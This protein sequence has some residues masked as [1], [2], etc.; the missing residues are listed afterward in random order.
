MSWKMLPL[1]LERGKHIIN[2]LPKVKR[3][4]KNEENLGTGVHEDSHTFHFY[5]TSYS[6]IKSSHKGGGLE[7]HYTLIYRVKF[8]LGVCSHGALA[9]M[10]EGTSMKGGLP[11]GQERGSITSMVISGEN[12]VL[13]N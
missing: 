8:R 2:Q 4:R 12:G 1:P 13:R 7:E 3:G 11:A 6:G 9:P 10:A 5:P